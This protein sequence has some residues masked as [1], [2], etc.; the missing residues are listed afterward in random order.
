LFAEIDRA[1][2]VFR[3]KVIHRIPR[4]IS[5]QPSALRDQLGP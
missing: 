5:F 3:R 4:S 1:Q 2:N